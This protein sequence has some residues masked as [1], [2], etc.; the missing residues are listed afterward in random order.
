MLLYPIQL[1]QSL[2]CAC[3]ASMRTFSDAEKIFCFLGF[4]RVGR[5]EGQA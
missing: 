1:V 3:Y 2:F 5:V 4:G